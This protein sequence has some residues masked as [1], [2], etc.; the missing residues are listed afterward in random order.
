MTTPEAPMTPVIR[1]NDVIKLFGN[2]TALS[3]VSFDVPPGVFFAL[4]CENTSVKT[5]TIR[6]LLRHEEPTARTVQVLSLSCLRDGRDIRSR[7]SYV[8]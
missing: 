1:L 8:P 5:T 3:H 2:N 6:F 7:V 4:L